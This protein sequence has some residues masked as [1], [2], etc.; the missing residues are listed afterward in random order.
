M[1][2]AAVSIIIPVFNKLAFTR[3]CLDRIARHTS[4]AV[5]YEVI[6]VDNGSTDGTAEFFAGA[7]LPANI[8]YHRNT[9][10]LGFAAANNVGAALASYDYLLLLNNDTLVQPGWLEQMLALAQSDP[11]IGVVGIKQL[12]PYTSTIHHTG[13][14]FTA[15]GVPQHIYP[16]TD[17][18]LPHV[19]KQREYQAVNGACL[20]IARRLYQECGG[21]DERYRN[22]YEDVDLCLSVRQRRRRVVCCTSAFIYHYGQISDTRTADDAANAAYFASK[23]GAGLK[24][25][26]PEFARADAHEVLRA[27]AVR[28]PKRVARALPDDVFYLADDVS[29]G[30]A[31]TWINTELALSLASLGVAVHIPA[32][33]ARGAQ[34]K[35]L[36]PM[37]LAEPPIGGVHIKWS[38]YWPQHLRL[39]LSGAINFE[40]FVINYL[41]G[42]PGSQPW[43][44]WL[45]CLR[46][47][48]YAKLPLSAF[49]RDVLLQTGVAERDCDVFSPGYSRE[50]ERVAPPPRR[51]DAYRFLTVTNSHDLERYGTTRLIDA[52]REAF[53]ASD[54]V[55]LVVKDYGAI[56]GDATLRNLLARGSGRARVELVTQFTSKEKLI[57]LYKSCDAFV[58]AHRGEGYG[59]KLLD[60]LACGLPAITP[61]FGGPTDYCTP[62]TCFPV[63]YA[64]APVGDC[65]DTRS[66]RITNQPLWCEPRVDSLVAQLRAAARDPA[67]AREV[68]ERAKAHVVDRFTWDA[69]AHGLLA[70]AARVRDSREGARPAPEQVRHTVGGERSPY[71]LGLRVSVVIPTCNRKAQLLECL[72]A[73]ERQSVL[74]QEFEVVVV[75]DGS[76]DGT[77]AAV[78]GLTLPFA[79]QFHRQENQGPGTAR[80]LG[81]AKARGELILFIGDDIIADSRLLETHLVAHATRPDAGDAVLGHIDWL[82]SIVPTA[83]MD[84]VC[85]ISS[86]QFAYH[87]IQALPSLDYRFFYTSNISLKRRFLVD[88][89]AD[90]IGFDPSFA[91]AAFEDSELAYRLEPRG[92]RL[93]YVPGALV[94]HD[95]P[96]DLAGFSKREYNVGRMAV[97]FYRKHPKIDD[98]LQVRWIGDWVDAVERLAAQPALLAQVREIDRRTDSFFAGMAR[99]LE[100]LMKLDLRLDSVLPRTP[101]PAERMTSTLHAVLGVI[102]DVERTRGKVHEW[103]AGVDDPDKID[104]AKTLLGC[105]RKLDVLTANP[106]ELARLRTSANPLGGEG[107]GDLRARVTELERELGIG[108][109]ARPGTSDAAGGG[110]KSLLRKAIFRRSVASRLRAA[111]IYLQEALKRRGGP[112]LA[113]YQRLRNSLRRMLS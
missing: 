88:A 25:D 32:A 90:G 35:A 44:Y 39:D 85:G 5:A 94:Y 13:I 100:D 76:T 48:R 40:F 52:Y 63:E 7:A 4:D 78:R 24:I 31:L 41:F 75:D 87:H 9:D 103:Y 29:Q 1:S 12:F 82:P 65:L 99:S 84:Y 37:M 92:L 66:L 3:Q 80:N 15:G 62:E 59:M 50:I 64:L 104:A 105:M 2:R 30:T 101:Q 47:N 49:C 18:S 26:E 98:M 83:V 71:W 51:P 53:T 46:Q 16:H 97:V 106:S 60:A 102:F 27:A 72:G 69:A 91:F 113:Q 86:L 8:R 81:I 55:V 54:P 77:E 36:K 11:S 96:M 79:L 111:D 67:A 17:A 20:L 107:A 95:H 110:V 58:S 23:W 68:G 74:P 28:A 93:T 33:T 108:R 22:G 43:D 57:E 10:N 42:R 61:L 112:Q 21:L 73:L 70:A 38:H 6:V 89:A 56:S 19:N 14:I 34:L 109:L 45:Q